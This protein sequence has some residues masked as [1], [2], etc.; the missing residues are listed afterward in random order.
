M[1]QK[2]SVLTLTVLAA[3]VLTAERFVTQGGAVATAASNSFGV[4]DSGGA[5]GALVPVT[6]L[7]TAVVAAGAA[8]A[9]FA[10]VEVGATGQAVTKAAGITVGIALQ[11]AAAAGDRIEVFLLS[12]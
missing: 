6:V 12:N 4:A 9:Q 8:I 7:G 5:I 2:I 10:R 1:T 11:A 3:A